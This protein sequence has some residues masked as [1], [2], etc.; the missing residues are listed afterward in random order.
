MI[1]PFPPFSSFLLGVT[2]LKV[3]RGITALSQS[4]VQYQLIKK[5]CYRPWGKYTL[6]SFFF[7]PL[8]I[9]MLYSKIVIEFN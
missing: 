7:F 4:V 3:T 2:S 9:L 8:D 5:F 6:Y 1:Y